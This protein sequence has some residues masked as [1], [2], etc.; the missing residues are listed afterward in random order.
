MTRTMK[1]AL[2]VGLLML[3][4]AAAFA[5]GDDYRRGDGDRDGGYYAVNHEAYEHNRLYQQ[6]LRDGREDREHGRGFFIRDRRWDDR[7]DRDAY[8]AGY[9]EGFGLYGDRDD[10]YYGRR[11]QSQAYNFG[12]QDGARIGARDRNGGHSFRPTNGDRYD[13]ADRGYNSSFG[14]KDAY[15]NAYRS[16]YVAGYEQGY[17]RGW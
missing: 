1:V 17:R 10:A 15:R 3:L 16:G 12:F 9:R 2:G 5:D 7:G 14:S 13:D 8:V 6:G 11:Y 4:C